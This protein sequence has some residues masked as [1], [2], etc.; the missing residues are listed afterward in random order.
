MIPVPQAATAACDLETC[1]YSTSS[2]LKAGTRSSPLGSSEWFWLI[3]SAV[4]ALL[5]L[6]VGAFLVRSVLDADTGTDK[7]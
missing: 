6:A 3:F 4:T 2:P 1:P 5:A 7:M